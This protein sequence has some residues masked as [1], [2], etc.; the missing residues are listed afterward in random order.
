MC[1]GGEHAR[2]QGAVVGIVLM[3]WREKMGGAGLAVVAAV[4]LCLPRFFGHCGWVFSVEPLSYE[5]AARGAE[6]G[7]M[8]AVVI[9]VGE[10]LFLGPVV[11][12]LLLL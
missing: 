11:I 2:S 4:V 5:R 3:G 8:A 7:G 9:V 1:G 10:R 6:G 12:P